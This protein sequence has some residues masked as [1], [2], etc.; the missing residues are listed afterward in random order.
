MKDKENNPEQYIIVP[1]ALLQA[2]I[3]PNSKLLYG[4]ILSLSRS[5]K[6]TFDELGVCFANNNY[7]SRN[8]GSVSI[9]TIQNSIKELEAKGFIH[10]N[11]NQERPNQKRRNLVPTSKGWDMKFVSSEQIWEG[12]EA[13][14]EEL[15]KRQMIEQ[16]NELKGSVNDNFKNNTDY[17]SPF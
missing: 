1:T 3:S 2:N 5:N 16:E 13:K 15:Q 4:L 17:E 8:L 10:R 14:L 9:T 12:N 11:I 6:F 7:L